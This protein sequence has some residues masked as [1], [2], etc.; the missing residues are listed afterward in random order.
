MSAQH[1]WQ[2]C[3][4]CSGTSGLDWETN[5]ASRYE[6]RAKGSGGSSW[7]GHRSKDKRYS[8]DNRL[9]ARKSSN[10]RSGLAPRCRLVT[11]WGWSRFQGFRCSPIKVA[12]EMG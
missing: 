8:G 11:S 12:R 1:E 10:R 2:P 4:E 7:E 3:V 9:I 5:K 6:S